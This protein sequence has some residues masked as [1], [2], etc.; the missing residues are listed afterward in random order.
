MPNSLTGRNI[1]LTPEVRDYVENKVDRL[2]KIFDNIQKIDVVLG[3]DKLRAGHADLLVAASHA[4]LKCAAKDATALAAFDLAMDK[5]ERQL[6]R[7]KGRL[8][9]NKKHAKRTVRKEGAEPAAEEAVPDG[10]AEIFEKV[11]RE[12]KGIPSARPIQL[13]RMTV[14]AAWEAF[15]KDEYHVLVYMDEHANRPRILHRE[16]TGQIFL[17]EIAGAQ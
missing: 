9:G 3:E 10:L 1:D 15:E 6:A 8:W 17:L 14:D 16:D 7:H 12:E 4:T 2:R 5:M 11:E 13:R